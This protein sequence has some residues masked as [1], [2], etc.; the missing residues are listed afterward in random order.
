M[1]RDCGK[2]LQVCTKCGEAKEV[3]IVEPTKVEEFKLD[4]DM[5]VMYKALS[6]RRRRHFKRYM[7]RRTNGD[8]ENLNDDLLNKLKALAVDDK[9]G[10]ELDFDIDQDFEGDDEDDESD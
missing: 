3:I 10:D 2:N 8:N 9:E 1:C 4:K 7:D 5:Q 6:E